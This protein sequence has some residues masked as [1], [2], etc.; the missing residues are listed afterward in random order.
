M[1]QN[2]LI[3]KEN[4]YKITD[5]VPSEQEVQLLAFPVKKV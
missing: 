1:S 4:H 3:H 2:K 5:S